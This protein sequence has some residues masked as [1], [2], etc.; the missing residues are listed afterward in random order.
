MRLGQ[1][2]DPEY[3][4]REG[5]DV[6]AVLATYFLPISVVDLEEPNSRRIQRQLAIAVC[7]YALTIC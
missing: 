3:A 2:L 5:K 4:L 6:P 7:D 1:K